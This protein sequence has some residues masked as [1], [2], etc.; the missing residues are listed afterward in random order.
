[1]IG[2]L[3]TG[4]FLTT[5]P[6]E[7][8]HV[9]TSSDGKYSVSAS[10]VAGEYDRDQ[11]VTLFILR[12]KDGTEIKVP[13]NRLS[14]ESRRLAT[15]IL[16]RRR[17]EARREE[18]DKRYQ[19]GLRKKAGKE[20]EQRI[21]PPFS[22][23]AT[24]TVNVDGVERSALVYQ[25]EEARAA[26]SPVLLHFHGFGGISEREAQSRRFHELWPEATVVY[27][28]GLNDITSG[29]GK[30]APGWRDIRHGPW[31]VENREVRFVDRLLEDLSARC[32]I[33]RQR[34]YATGHSNGGFVTFLLLLERP[35][36]LAAFAPVAS[37]GLCVAEARTPRPVMYMFGDEDHVFDKDKPHRTGMDLANTT[38]ESLL[39]LNKCSHERKTTLPNGCQ[40]FAP[41]PGGEPVVWCYY[42]GGHGAPDGA[43]KLVVQFLQEHALG[44][45]ERPSP[46]ADPE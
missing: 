23:P 34:I 45:P 18:R 29:K 15:R 32:K 30:T 44:D 10:L 21:L 24:L 3:S 35:N 9:W 36:V 41:E 27:P 2:L 13:A 11:K 43:D 40:V 8:I 46:Q 33:D 20:A 37:Y 39:K 4:L 7:D 38:L 28:Q 31:N 22:R 26:P 19:T 1:M 5:T 12:K 25:G 17:S 6:D 16:A 14:N 42:H